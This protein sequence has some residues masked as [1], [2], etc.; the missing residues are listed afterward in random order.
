[1]LTHNYRLLSKRLINNHM[2]LNQ[3][4]RMFTAYSKKQEA[5]LFAQVSESLKQLKTENGKSLDELG[6]IHSM[7]VDS[8]HGIVS[9]KLN[10]TKDYRKAKSL[11]QN[12][13]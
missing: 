1:M 2:R 7:G 11:V 3:N 12:A 13:I 10:L 4:I 8:A 5:E 9:V 6:M